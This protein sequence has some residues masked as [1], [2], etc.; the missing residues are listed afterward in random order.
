MT[1]KIGFATQISDTKEIKIIELNKINKR[2][3]KIGL[4]EEIINN[5]GLA[6]LIEI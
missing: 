6:Y 1:A 5:K 4:I 3:I 2:Y